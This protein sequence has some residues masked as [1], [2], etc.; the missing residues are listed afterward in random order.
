M[1]TVAPVIHI[2][3][4]PGSGKMTIG[5]VLAK[6]IG[7]RLL[8]NHLALDPANAL[9][10]RS[11]P[12]HFDLREALRRQIYKAALTLPPDVPLI[13][14]DALQE[15]EFDRRL[16]APT[17]T[18]ADQRG[19]RLLAVTLGISATENRRRLTQ[20]DRVTRSKLT[21]VDVL[22]TLR[23]TCTLLRPAGAILI[24]VSNLNAQ[25]AADKIVHQLGLKDEADND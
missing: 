6:Q 2:C 21:Q 5:R 14:T 20:P 7:G 1:T 13:V 9:F 15:A 16:F 22:E 10:A 18:L 25:S 3:G 24:D 17:Q 8:H 4:W 11:D 19:A 12:A 23:D